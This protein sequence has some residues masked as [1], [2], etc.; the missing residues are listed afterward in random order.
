MKIKVLLVLLL[1]AMSSFS[2]HPIHVSITE[3]TFDQ[4]DQELEVVI[5][6]FV[7]DLETSVMKSNQ[8]EELDLSDTAPAVTSKLVSD[9]LAT[10]FSISVNGKERS[11]K[12]LGQEIEGLSMLCYIQVAKVSSLE[13]IE[14]KN[15]VVTEL[16]EDQSNIINVVVGE[17]V[18]SLRLMRYH[19]AGTLKF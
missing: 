3:I 9:Y 12:Y 8:T 5:R 13:V 10:R 11:W 15:T 17:N 1:L 7:D 4:K 14:I 16:Y 2:F 19:A 6:V 18:R